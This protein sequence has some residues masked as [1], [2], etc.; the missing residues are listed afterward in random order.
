MCAIYT[1][2]NIYTHIH[3][4][5]HIVHNI[6]LALFSKGE[7][8]VKIWQPNLAG[9]PCFCCGVNI[10][11]DVWWNKHLSFY[12]CM[13]EVYLASRPHQSVLHELLSDHSFPFPLLFAVG[14]KPHFWVKC[15][16]FAVFDWPSSPLESRLWQ[17]KVSVE[18]LCT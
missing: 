11:S 14:P 18:L 3:I 6:Y 16:P 2:Y 7:N 13:L 17:G 5:I 9:T 1:I 15:H 4:H 12:S 8:W 10:H